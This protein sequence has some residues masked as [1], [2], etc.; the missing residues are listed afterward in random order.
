M[1]RL[2]LTN[3]RLI[4]GVT[5]RVVPGASVTVEDG[6]IVEVLDGRRSPATVG[7]RVIDLRESYL[8]PGLWDAHVHLEWPRVPA[9]SVAELTVQ[10]AANATQALLESG[11]TGMRMAG[12]P[13]FIDVALKR[14]YDANQLAGPRMFTAGW[15]L[16][17]TAGHALGTGFAKR[18]D[19]P[20]GVVQAVREQIEQGVDHIKLNLT[21]GIMGPAWDQHT[22][23]FFLPEELEAAFRV[24]AQRGFKVMA[25]AAS[26]D[27]VKAALRLGAWTVEHGYVMD[28]ECLALFRERDAWY[29]PT[30]GITH[31]TPDQATTVA[32]KRWVEQRNLPPDLI[33]RAEAAV[34]EHRAWFLKALRSGVRMALGSDI[35]PVKDAVLLEMGLW[36]KAGATPWQTLLAATRDAAELCGVGDR[37][38]TVE[39]GKRADLIVVGGNPLDDVEHLRALELVVKDGRLVADHRISRA[40]A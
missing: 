37:L 3:A 4:D 13:H 30:L 38:G 19:G 14:A 9:A 25:H 12:T 17:T 6:R 40:R 22:H 5:E 29:V 21:G 33:R 7:A 11:I 32:E 39:V 34:G 20:L 36:V 15:F 26:P 35:R 28:D 16:T 2:V 18:C 24:C 23:A 31:L 1:T 10:Y 8:L 27:A